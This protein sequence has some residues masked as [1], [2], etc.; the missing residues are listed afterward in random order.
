[1]RD[2][3]V[4]YRRFSFTHMEITQ[5]PKIPQR[6]QYFTVSIEV[7]EGGVP[8][9]LKEC[10]AASYTE[11]KKKEFC[12]QLC[13]EDIMLFAS[14]VETNKEKLRGEVRYHIVLQSR[15]PPIHA[16]KRFVVLHEH[17]LKDLRKQAAH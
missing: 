10:G 11:G 2:A 15:F 14:L 3:R 7:T 8:I 17:V 6:Q 5:I 9:F 13:K 12:Y 1:M 4:R 16:C